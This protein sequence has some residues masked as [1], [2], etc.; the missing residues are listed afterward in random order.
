MPA[1]P[2]S[3]VSIEIP[4]RDLKRAADF[5]AGLFGWSF[6]VDTDNDFR[7]LFAPY[8]TAITGAITNARPVGS[9]GARIVVAVEDVQATARRAIELGGGPGEAWNSDIGRFMELVDPDGNHLW[10]LEGTVGRMTRGPQGPGRAH[11]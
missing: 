5:Y 1:R 10:V 8:G 6:E 2:G 7:W 11:A 4:V 9:G 3:I